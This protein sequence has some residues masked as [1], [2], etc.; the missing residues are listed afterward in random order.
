[1]VTH[2]GGLTL[3]DLKRKFESNDAEMEKLRAE[4]AEVKKRELA[5]QVR[6][7]KVEEAKSQT[8]RAQEKDEIERLHEEIAK[9]KERELRDKLEAQRIRHKLQNVDQAELG[10]SSEQGRELVLLARSRKRCAVNRSRVSW[11][12]CGRVPEPRS[13]RIQQQ[14]KW[15]G[16]L[17]HR[18]NKHRSRREQ[19]AAAQVE[20]AQQRRTYCWISIGP[21]HARGT[22][23]RNSQATARSEGPAATP[24]A[25]TEQRRG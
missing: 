25:G 8:R 19:R 13:E 2:V 24:A 16:V 15:E 5:D 12:S 17:A 10:G 3:D 14:A 11:S 20:R 18:D 9:L 4:R 7:L 1:M 6:R 22:E 23:R 21:R